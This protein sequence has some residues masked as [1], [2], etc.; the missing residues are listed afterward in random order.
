MICANSGEWPIVEQVARQAPGEP[1]RG[2][3]RESVENVK[4]EL[5]IKQITLT[6]QILEGSVRLH[7]LIDGIDATLID[8]AAQEIGEEELER[9]ARELADKTFA[10]KQAQLQTSKDL[11]QEVFVLR[12]RRIIGVR[13]AGRLQ[14]IQETG[15]RVRMHDSVE[16]DL[17]PRRQA[18]DDLA[19]PVEA[20]LV[21][22]M[23]EW[24]W[25]QRVMQ[26]AVR[27][28]YRLD[29]GIPIDTLRQPF[30]DLVASWLAGD[31][32]AELATRSHLSIDDV[33][34]VHTHVVTFVLQTLVEQAVALLERLLAAQG[35]VI[36]EAVLALPDHLR[37]GVPTEAARLLASKGVRHRR[38]SV[39][40][41]AEMVGFNPGAL[42]RTAL[43]EIGHQ[44]LTDDRRGGRL[45][46]GVSCLRTLFA[47]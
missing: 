24:A 17:L 18:W 26:S 27:Q 5:A 42:S 47:T 46:S 43:F 37:F 4:D 2:A 7:T 13:S 20:T 21:Q 15:A 35:T 29:G 3:L 9:L 32:F 41:G 10:S 19:D 38:A 34:G 28:A 8:L 1:V 36:S 39:E 11:L 22:V 12:A 40:L 44:M 45:V 23:L 31:R 14:W 33:L 25:N 6:N 16:N 30:F